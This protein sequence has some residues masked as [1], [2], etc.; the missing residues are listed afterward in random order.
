M[1]NEVKTLYKNGLEEYLSD[2][3]NIND[4]I[5]TALYLSDI[6][7]HVFLFLSEVK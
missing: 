1:W 7:I 4:F 3:W 6:A 5:T 2:M